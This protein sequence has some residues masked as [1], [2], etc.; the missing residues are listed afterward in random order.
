[1]AAAIRPIRNEADYRAAVARIE[2]LMDARPGS[3]DADELDVLATLVDRYEA[4][5]YPIEA[6]TPVDAL[7]FRMEQAGLSR[8]DLEPMIGTRARVSEVLSG[9]RTLT[10]AM[11]R[12]LHAG[13]G[14]PAESLL[15]LPRAKPT[16]LSATRRS[17]GA[18]SRLASA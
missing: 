14:I 7:L 18:A 16:R 10:L 13:L 11:I 1:M 8:R 2:A 17:A 3:G 6:P 4:Q 15:G 12:A 9:K 5:R